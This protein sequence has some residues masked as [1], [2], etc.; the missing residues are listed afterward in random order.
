MSDQANKI[1]PLA[2]KTAEVVCGMLPFFSTEMKKACVEAAT[3]KSPDTY[4]TLTSY[5]V[6]YQSAQSQSNAAAEKKAASDAPPTHDA[7][8]EKNA[9]RILL[10][11]WLARFFETPEQRR[12]RI[13]QLLQESMAQFRLPDFARNVNFPVRQPEEGQGGAGGEGG[14]GGDPV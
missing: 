11:P 12:A 13:A 6:E 9:H 3:K 1:Q 4:T 2:R 8:Q 5:R 14:S 10:P 7:S